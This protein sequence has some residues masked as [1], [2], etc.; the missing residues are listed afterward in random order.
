MQ[1]DYSLAESH[2]RYG[3][4]LA[5]EV[6]DLLASQGYAIVHDY[7]PRDQVI[8]MRAALEQ[9]MP[10]WHERCEA[11]DLG[12]RSAEEAPSRGVRAIPSR[13]TCMFPYEQQSLNHAIVNDPEAISFAGRWLGTNR[14]H[15]R[16][17]PLPTD[18]S[19]DSASGS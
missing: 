3:R 17:A 15:Y 6:F 8:Q 1:Y 16:R 9:A 19:S 12:K 2:P 7:L 4:R 5:T 14:I 13:D 18:L 10:P 11:S